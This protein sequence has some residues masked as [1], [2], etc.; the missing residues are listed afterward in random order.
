[1]V[2]VDEFPA[3]ARIGFG[4]KDLLT[5][6]PGKLVS[7]AEAAWVLLAPLVLVTAPT[8]IVLVRFALTFIVTLTV[9]AELAEAAR[10]PPLK[11]K[12]V[13]PGMA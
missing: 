7:V 13:A 2:K 1:M 8:R 5:L 11:E 4:E 10:L 3:P 6:A 9:I 12:D